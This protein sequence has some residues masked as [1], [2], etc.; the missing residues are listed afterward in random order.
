[1]AILGSNYL[2]GCNSIPS[3][4]AAGSRV[5]FAQTSAPTSWT[6]EV[7]PSF[8]NVA[9]RIIGGAD[10]TSLSPGGSQPFTVTFSSATGIT[11]PLS[12][13]SNLTVQQATNFIQINN[14][15]SGVSVSQ[16][17]IAT[18]QMVAH[19][20][21]YTRRAAG[22]TNINGSAAQNLTFAQQFDSFGSTG[23]GQNGQH[24]H[25]VT[26]SQHTH[27]TS[28]GAHNHGQTDSQHTHTFTMTQRNF[29]VLY[30]DIIIASKD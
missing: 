15:S 29:G 22:T 17:A 30:M 13:P 12:G 10:G 11:V 16:Y 25:G 20:H 19:S 23:T 14:N 28:T 9:L 1:M 24:D 2:N 8:D 7:N 18:S 27:P 4:I 3:F 5:S 26:D 21:Q 6:K